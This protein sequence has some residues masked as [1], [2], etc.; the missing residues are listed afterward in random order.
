MRHSLSFFLFSL[1]TMM[2]SRLSYKCLEGPVFSFER[3]IFVCASGTLCVDRT[4]R[5]ALLIVNSDIR[6]LGRCPQLLTLDPQLRSMLQWA[7]ASMADIPHIQLCPDRELQQVIV[8]KL[9]MKF[10]FKV[11]HLELWQTGFYWSWFSV[12]TKPLANTMMKSNRMLYIV[13]CVSTCYLAQ[14]SKTPSHDMKHFS[15]PD[16]FLMHSFHW[17]Y[18]KMNNMKAPQK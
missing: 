7:A 15:L 4:P 14:T 6:E 5:T 16:I 11:N 13:P 12:A 17:L 9:S 10:V 2:R 8:L 18:F 3:I 1:K